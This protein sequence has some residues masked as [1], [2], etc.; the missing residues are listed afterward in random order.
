MAWLQGPSLNKTKFLA[1]ILIICLFL[2]CPF[3]GSLGKLRYAPDMIS[4]RLKIPLTTKM[5]FSAVYAYS[6]ALSTV[7]LLKIKEVFTT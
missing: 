5:K 7:G 4:S 1:H 3:S 2:S 6:Y